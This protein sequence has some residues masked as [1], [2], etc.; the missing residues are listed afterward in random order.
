M[1]KLEHCPVCQS[2]TGQHDRWTSLQTWRDSSDSNRW[3][4]LECRKCGLDYLNPQPIWEELEPYYRED[5]DAYADDDDPVHGPSEDEWLE[6]ARQTGKLRHVEIERG[7]R[8]LDVGCAT[9]R[10]LRA[11]EK[12]GATAKGVEPSPLAAKAAKDAGVDLFHGT[13]E[14]YLA[15]GPTERFDIIT[16]SHVLE[17]VSDPVATLTTCKKLLADGGIIW[18]AVPNR[19]HPFYERLGWRWHGTDLPYHLLHFTPGSLSKAGEHA[20]LLVRRV[21]TQSDIAGIRGAFTTWLRHR[22]LLPRKLTMLGG[23]VRWVIDA[24]SAKLKHDYDS[25]DQGEAIEIE[26]QLPR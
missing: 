26:F 12:L 25:S 17:H 8:L 3:S 14:Q 19:L 21:Q 16:L 4:M 6:Q 23:P 22:F 10:F 20:G 15:S 11:A 2:A 13:V 1:R 24:I 18:I 7:T 5:Y 9:G